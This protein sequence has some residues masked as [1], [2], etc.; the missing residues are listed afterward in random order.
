MLQLSLL[1][2]AAVLSAADA[3]L[4]LTYQGR[5]CPPD[6]LIRMFDATREVSIPTWFSIGTMALLGACCLRLGRQSGRRIWLPIGAGFVYLAIDD[7]CMIHER[8]GALV[9]PW[10]GDHGVYAWVLVLAPVFALGGLFVSM[11]IWR[12]LRDTPRRRLWLL[13]GMGALLAALVLE[14]AE[15]WTLAS[16]YELRGIRLLSYSKWLEESLELFAP[17]MLLGALPDRLPAAVSHEASVSAPP[18]SNS[19]KPLR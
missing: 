4:R 8:V 7:A 19:A 10:I 13:A 1:L 12:S 16:G 2:A 5:S 3:M 18:D 9:M 17:T 15:E 6:S 14:A 11:A